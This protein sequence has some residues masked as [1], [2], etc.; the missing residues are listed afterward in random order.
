MSYGFSRLIR[1]MVLAKRTARVSLAFD[2]EAVASS[3]RGITRIWEC[4]CV[5]WGELARRTSFTHNRWSL[6]RRAMLVTMRTI[7]TSPG[8]I[9][10]QVLTETTNECPSSIRFTKSCAKMDQERSSTFHHIR[11]KEQGAFLRTRQRRAWLQPV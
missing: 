8:P 1:V 11:M 5:L 2:K 3:R 4:P 6:T 9:I 10:I 7:R